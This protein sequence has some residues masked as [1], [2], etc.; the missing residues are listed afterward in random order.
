MLD[1]GFYNMDCLEAMKDF[2]DNY[3]DLAVVDPPYGSGQP[4]T[5]G[6]GKK[7]IITASDK[8]LTNISRGGGQHITKERIAESR[9]E[10]GAMRTGGTWAK[11]YAKK[12]Y[13]GTYR[14]KK[15]TLNNFFVS[16]VIR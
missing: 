14:L 7:S 11:K 6:G 13:R 2:P 12:L 9:T 8:G 3:F 5:E 10:H 15:N 16:H 1:F 4:I